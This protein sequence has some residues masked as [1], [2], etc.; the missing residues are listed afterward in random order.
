MRALGRELR[1]AR[2][3]ADLTQEELARKA[4]MERTYISDVERGA[5]IPSVVLFIKLCKAIGIAP[6]K[7]MRRLENR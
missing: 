7:V 4:K 2:R 6:S 5:H 3:D 1:R